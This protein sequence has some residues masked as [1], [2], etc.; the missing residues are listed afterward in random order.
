MGSLLVGE[1]ITHVHEVRPNTYTGPEIAKN[2][3]FITGVI[4]LFLGLVRL[5]WIVE[6]IPYIP[7]SAFI[8]AASIT[9]MCTQFPVMMGI[10]NINTREAPYRVFINTLKNLGKTRLDA[11]IGLTCLLLLD[12]IRRFCS[13]MEVQQ[14]KRKRL[15]STVSSLRLTFAML[16]YTLISWLVNRTLPQGESKFRIVGHIEKG[17]GVWMDNM[18][19]HRTDIKIQALCTLDLRL[20]TRTFWHLSFHRVRPSSSFL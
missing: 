18:S 10:P 5:G 8:T 1:V 15:W 6:V 20:R 12:L 13:K 17:E 11:A 7:V 2:L 9:I 4:L 19:A 16:L 3:S 14:P